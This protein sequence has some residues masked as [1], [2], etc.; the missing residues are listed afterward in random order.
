MISTVLLAQLW[1]KKKK[2]DKLHYLLGEGG[3]EYFGQLTR[4]PKWVLGKVINLDWNVVY[5]LM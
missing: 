2:K 4:E 3:G 1:K 5:P